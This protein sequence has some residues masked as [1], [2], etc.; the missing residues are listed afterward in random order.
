MARRKRLGS[1]PGSASWA[2][3]Q[4]SSRPSGEARRPSEMPPGDRHA[5]PAVSTRC[6]TGPQILGRYARHPV[7]E[8]IAVMGRN[9]VYCLSRFRHGKGIRRFFLTAQQKRASGPTLARGASSD[10]AGLTAKARAETHTANLALIYSSGHDTS[11]YRA[12][13]ARFARVADGMAT[14]WWCANNSWTADLRNVDI[15]ITANSRSP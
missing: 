3:R 5:V 7:P 4:L 2:V 14:W 11:C 6:R 12:H 10:P 9:A 8:K 1:G 15:G 13:Y